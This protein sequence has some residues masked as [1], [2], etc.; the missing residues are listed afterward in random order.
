MRSFKRK[1]WPVTKYVLGAVKIAKSS[2]VRIT[3]FLEAIR[4]RVTISE[5][6]WRSVTILGLDSSKAMLHIPFRLAT[7]GQKKSP[8]KAKDSLPSKEAG[9]SGQKKSG[10]NIKKKSEHHRG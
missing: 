6:A 10:L 7:D 5:T 2:F 8:K 1:F 4:S 3:S 9:Q